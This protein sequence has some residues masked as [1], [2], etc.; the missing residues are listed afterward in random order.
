LNLNEKELITFRKKIIKWGKKNFREYPWRK[1]KDPYKI[2]ISEIM[3]H[4]TKADQVVP[5]Y[6]RFLLKFPNIYD[7]ARAEINE[8]EKI[9]KKLGLGWRIE[10]LSQTARIIVNQHCGVIPHD[11]KSL[12]ELPGVGDYIA[13][14]VSC[15]AFSKPEPLLDTN[16]VRIVGRIFNLDITESSRR[17][18]EYCE[19]MKN[20]I[21]KKKPRR[22]NFA[23]LDLGAILC[24]KR[25]EPRCLECPLKTF[26]SYAKKN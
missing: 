23:L 13:S 1:T 20:L 16:T 17:N 14:A 6:N 15:F 26:C 4:R 10:K 25:G 8:I 9:F 3:L 5:V 22:F 2:L 19:L 11:K 7:L 12:L 21:D 24:L 18:K